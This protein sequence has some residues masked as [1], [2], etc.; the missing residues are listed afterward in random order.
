MHTFG[1]VAAAIPGATL[2]QDDSIGN[3][4]QVLIGSSFHGVQRVKVVATPSSSGS[5]SGISVRTAA[6]DVCS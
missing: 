4:I 5:G 2:Q 3:K 1:T 6:Q